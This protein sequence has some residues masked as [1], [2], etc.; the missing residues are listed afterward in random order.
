MGRPESEWER[1]MR[2]QEVM[3]R[4]L[5]GERHWF[6]AADILGWTCAR[7]VGGGSS[8]SATGCEALFDRR[9]Q[10]PS[11]RRAPP[12]EVERVLRLYR[13]RYRGFNV[14][15]FYAI[16]RREH[17]VRLSYS[18]VKDALQLARLVAKRRPRG[19][20]AQRREPRACVG[21]SRRDASLSRLLS[22]NHIRTGRAWHLASS[23]QV[24][25]SPD[26][27]TTLDVRNCW[28]KRC[29]ARER[30][31]DGPSARQ[32]VRKCHPDG[33]DRRC[34]GDSE[35]RPASPRAARHLRLELLGPV[36]NQVDVR[37]HRRG[38]WSQRLCQVEPLSVLRHVIAACG[39]Q[40]NHNANPS[41]A[42][43]ARGERAVGAP[44][45]R[46]L[47]TSCEPCGRDRTD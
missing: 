18:W 25:G 19:G 39:E 36:L 21:E 43:S 7:C 23:S 33:T 29:S 26:S 20:T 38:R 22:R 24:A 1:A 15:H 12:A 35:R 16:A 32:A 3:M 13:E 4:A 47:P 30:T 46:M 40:S 14:R 11:P 41:K 10:M 17:A 37:H 9:M 27:A 44:Q 42:K 31:R 34:V 2:V 6:Q 28:R 45:P 5:S 8:S